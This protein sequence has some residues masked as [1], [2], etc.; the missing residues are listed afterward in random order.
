MK[1]FNYKLVGILIVIAIIANVSCAITA[2]RYFSSFDQ[3]IVLNITEPKYK[4]IFNANGGSGTMNDQNFE[5]GTSQNLSINNFEKNGY[6][7][8]VSSKSESFILFSS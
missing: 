6:V 7:F 3:E 1:R 8:I 4:I 2:A 5:Y